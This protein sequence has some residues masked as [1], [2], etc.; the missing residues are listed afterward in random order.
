MTLGKSLNFSPV[1]KVNNA[2]H[3]VNVKTGLDNG[4]ENTSHALKL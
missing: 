1:P 4:A 2:N 3:K